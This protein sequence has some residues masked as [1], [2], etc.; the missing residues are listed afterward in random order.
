MLTDQNDPAEQ[1]PFVQVPAE[2]VPT[3]Q[4]SATNLQ[5]ADDL[6]TTLIQADLVTQPAQQITQ[7]KYPPKI[8]IPC[9]INTF[10]TSTWKDLSKSD[11]IITL[12]KKPK[13]CPSGKKWPA[14][15]HHDVQP[16]ATHIPATQS[17]GTGQYHPPAL[18]QVMEAKMNQK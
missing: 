5:A 1:V 14:V 15:Q 12:S 7:G 9:Y 16:L 18:R 8:R 2:Q 17:P 11:N 3:M 10:P 4:M 13:P 6:P